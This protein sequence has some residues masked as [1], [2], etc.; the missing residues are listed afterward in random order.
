MKPHKRE[1]KAPI[2]KARTV[3]ILKLSQAKITEPNNTMKIPIYL[4]SSCKKAAAPYKINLKNFYL[5]Y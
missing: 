2:T 1:V 4:Y 3:Q 5:R